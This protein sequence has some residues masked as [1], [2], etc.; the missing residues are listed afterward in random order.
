MYRKK[1]I[2]YPL[3]ISTKYNAF[4]LSR[5]LMSKYILN[6]MR[7]FDLKKRD[8]N[9]SCVTKMS[10]DSQLLLTYIVSLNY[11]SSI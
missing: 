4:L 1:E 5:E 2:A 9:K 6:R 11:L 3:T 7:E 10:K 8:F